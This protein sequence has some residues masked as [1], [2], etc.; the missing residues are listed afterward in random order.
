M[1]SG[2]RRTT[3]GPYT[4]PPAPAGPEQPAGPVS[5]ARLRSAE[6]AVRR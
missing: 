6:H 2:P 4:L 3:A 5:R 1:T